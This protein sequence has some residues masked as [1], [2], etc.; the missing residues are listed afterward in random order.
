MIWGVCGPGLMR[1][2]IEYNP[3]VFKG[4]PSFREKPFLSNSSTNTLIPESFVKHPG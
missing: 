3:D 1:A 4:G 2:S